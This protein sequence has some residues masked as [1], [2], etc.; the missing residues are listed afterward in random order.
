MEGRRGRHP[1]LKA[2]EERAQA[3]LSQRETDAFVVVSLC[4]ETTHTAR[5][6]MSRVKRKRV[7]CRG[8]GHCEEGEEGKV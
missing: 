6:R 1:L 5:R 8:Y 3:R 7:R 2:D 4:V